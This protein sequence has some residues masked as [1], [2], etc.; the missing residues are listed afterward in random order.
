MNKIEY[1]CIPDWSAHFDRSQDAWLAVSMDGLLQQFNRNVPPLLG[2]PEDGLAGKRLSAMLGRVDALSCWSGCTYRGTLFSLKS[3]ERQGAMI[4]V[5]EVPC[6]LPGWK[7]RLLR[8]TDVS[9]NLEIE[10]NRIRKLDRLTALADI[11]TLAETDRQRWLDE[12]MELGAR[13]LGLELGLVSRVNHGVLFLLAHNAPGLMKHN[14]SF[15]LEQTYCSITIAAADV[16]A[17]S[18]FLQ[19]AYASHPCYQAFGFQSYIGVPL[20][21]HGELYGTVSFSS[22][23]PL[24]A[25]FDR[26]DK[27][28][29]KLLARWVGG[30]IERMNVER[31]LRE[32]H[33]ELEEK[34]ELLA[35]AEKVARLGHWRLD[36]QGRTM[37]LSE[38]AHAFL[39]LPPRAEWGLGEFEALIATADRDAWREQLNACVSEGRQIGL[40]LRMINADGYTRWLSLRGMRLDQP[41]PHQLFGVLL[42]I[43]DS[44]QAQETILFQASHDSL[45]GLINR[46]LLFDR[47]GQ[48]VRRCQRTDGHFAVLFIDL[49]FFKVINDRY[50]HE[51]GDRVL[52]QVGKRLVSALRK[53]DT[54]GRFGGD[55]FIAIIPGV[56]S[57]ELVSHMIRKILRRLETPI[58]FGR[59][60]LFI[61]AS[62][63]VSLYPNDATLPQELIRKADNDMYLVKEQRRILPDKNGKKHT[64]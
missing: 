49:D 21:V 15:P 47:L 35:M 7:G 25:G 18:P 13:A 11:M 10:N 52:V 46:V 6:P 43:T 17:I 9:E 32:S 59:E 28:F 31:R 34:V 44:K 57:R 45:T 48:E 8:L 3:G 41:H 51:A 4:A 58:L 33:S 5:E 12:A 64:R 42:D 54:V 38:E 26:N 53:S 14:Q 61:S 1:A 19:S 2:L 40:E 24:Q 39:G 27:V 22:K 30:V 55:E 16:V 36:L 56:D 63:G 60:E 62:V 37:L 29:V 23:V 20:W 50:G